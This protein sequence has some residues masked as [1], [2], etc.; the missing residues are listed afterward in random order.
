MKL[1]RSI[2]TLLVIGAIGGGVYYVMQSG[3]PGGTA[4][5]SAAMAAEVRSPS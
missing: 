4:N 2:F 5:A 3:P 1:M